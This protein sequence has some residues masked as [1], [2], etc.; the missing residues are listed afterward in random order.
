[1]ARWFEIGPL[2]GGE[3]AG[4]RRLEPIHP[5]QAQKNGISAQCRKDNEHCDGMIG[6]G[7]TRPENHIVNQV[8]L[9]HGVCTLP[10]SLHD[11]TSEDHGQRSV[12]ECQEAYHQHVIGEN[13]IAKVIGSLKYYRGE[14]NNKE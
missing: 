8:H 3:Q 5:A 9:V 7:D 10:D 13:D 2:S 1:M 4:P 14:K 11:E 6:R 12:H